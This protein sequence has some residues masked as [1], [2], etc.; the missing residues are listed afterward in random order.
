MEEIQWEHYF[1][2][3]DQLKFMGYCLDVILK[4]Q[5]RESDIQS[6]IFIWALPP[7]SIRS[8]SNLWQIR[9]AELDNR[10]SEIGNRKSEIGSRRRRLVRGCLALQTSP[11]RFASIRFAMSQG[12]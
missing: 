8:V 4:S 9:K 1:L 2:L 10:K 12:I 6:Y 7:F 5:N 3:L 11:L